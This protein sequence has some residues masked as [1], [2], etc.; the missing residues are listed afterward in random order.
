M[1]DNMFC[2]PH[3]VTAPEAIAYM[4]VGRQHWGYCKLHRTKWCLGENLFSGWQEEDKEI[5]A[6]N[7][8]T[9]AEFVDVTGAPT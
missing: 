8:A 7:A 5:W 6:R 4:N 1:P 2:C 9:L 3:H